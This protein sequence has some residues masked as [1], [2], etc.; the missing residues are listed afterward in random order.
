MKDDIRMNLVIYERM[1][2][3]LER[4]VKTP[5]R[6]TSHRVEKER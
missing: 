3:F 6:D 1:S 2:L 5:F 4:A